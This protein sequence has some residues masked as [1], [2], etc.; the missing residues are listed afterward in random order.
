MAS[1]KTSAI[2]NLL[3]KAW[4]ERWSDIQWGIHLKSVLPRGGSGDAYNLSGLILEQALVSPIPNAL[5]ISYLRHSLAAQTI[6]H[7]SLLETIASYSDTSFLKNRPHCTSVLLELISLSKALISKRSK[8]EECLSLNSSLLKIA[9]WLL[10]LY[11]GIIETLHRGQAPELVTNAQKT[12]EILTDFYKDEFILNL[13]YVVK[14]DDKDAYSK[15]GQLCKQIDSLMNTKNSSLPNEIKM[16]YSSEVMMGLKSLDP[17]KNEG[18][19]V[20]IA[21]EL[22]S[23]V[24]AIQPMLMFEALFHPTSDLNSLSQYF[25][26]LTYSLG[27]VSFSDMVHEILRSLLLSISQKEGLEPLKLDA[28]ILVRLPTLLEKLFKLYKG[29]DSNAP[30]KT[31]TDLYKAFDKLVGNESLLDSTDLRCKCNIIDVLLRIVSKSSIPLMTDTEKEDV[32]KKRQKKISVNA[33]IN[34]TLIADSIIG[35]IRNFELT[36]KAEGTLDNVLSTFE[37]ADHSKPDSLESL[38]GVLINVFK[39]ESFD[40]WQA[41]TC[42]TG[43]LPNL[44]HFLLKF[45]QQSQ[46]SQGESI[47]NSSLRAALFDMTFLMIVYCA[48]CFGIQVIQDALKK[49][50]NEFINRWIREF[51]L[52]SNPGLTKDIFDTNVDNLMQQL[53][54]GELRTQVVKWQNVCSSIHLA[55]KEIIFAR[56][57]KII[58]EE[59]YKKMLTTMNSKLCSLPVCVTAWLANYRYTLP[60][61]KIDLSLIAQEFIQITNETMTKNANN[62][63]KDPNSVVPYFKERVA[64]MN[65]ILKRFMIKSGVAT[66]DTSQEDISYDAKSVPMLDDA[67]INE[68]LEKALLELWT[69]INHK[70]F[71]DIE[72]AWKLK[73]LYKSGGSHWFTS[74]LI[75]ALLN[76]T[77]QDD[78]NKQTELLRALFHIDIE[79]TTSA[80]LQHVVPQYL[81]SK[82]KEMLT[83]PRGTA[84]AKLLIGC[85]YTTMSYKKEAFSSSSSTTKKRG[86]ESDIQDEPS[87]KMRKL[88]QGVEHMEALKDGKA[89]EQVSDLNEAI[90]GFFK[91]IHSVI[92]CQVRSDFD[93]K[94]EL[95]FS[96]LFSILGNAFDTCYIICIPTT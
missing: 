5:L 4:R 18:K 42:A 21:N 77:Y 66:T 17:L 39:C 20:S 54:T 72:A 50:P 80:L 78:L 45:N 44:L 10:K 48:Q 71:I 57:Q 31:P 73:Y 3:L 30:L 53:A 65:S 88:A 52:S 40:M 41:V 59:L 76:I 13:M 86:F 27:N 36:Y 82:G 14:V 55:T 95:E 74:V 28:F 32:L 96:T 12:F 67:Q 46:E 37:H 92:L 35:N 62:V 70:G 84:L 60:S 64:I 91:L 1:E 25:H 56:N 11:A 87:L 29:S 6:S 16:D 7:G 38:I 26:S 49:S 22:P 61:A 79:Q 19:V 34:P 90:G 81:Q 63:Q 94:S 2:R 89:I 24:H 93:Q 8:P 23:F 15:M 85:L 51:M 33:Q 58:S 75:K 83:D 43:K 69:K 68:P 47:R 9:T